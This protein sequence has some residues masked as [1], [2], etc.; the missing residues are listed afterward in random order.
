MSLKNTEK[1]SRKMSVE[2]L[3]VQFSKEIPKVKVFKI[4]CCE[5]GEFMIIND[6][7]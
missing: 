5:T 7:Y 1:F 3:C 2:C 4:E 6:D